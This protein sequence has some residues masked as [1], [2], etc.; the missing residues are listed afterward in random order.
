MLITEQEIVELKEFIFEL[1]SI[2]NSVVV[3][4]GKRDAAALERIGY[5]GE[6]LKFHNFQGI[7]K[8][9]DFASKYENIIVLFDRDRKGRYFTRKIIQLL[10]RSTKI[11]TS[12]K[13]RL[14]KVTKGKITFI[15]QLICYESFLV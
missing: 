7:V 3:V 5:K 2:K 10:D 4:E 15:E 13:R 1:N 9:T 8:F 14:Q 12:Y 6:I 11:D